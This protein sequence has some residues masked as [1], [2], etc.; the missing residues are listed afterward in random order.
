MKKTSYS[1]SRY[2]PEGTEYFYGYPA[3]ED[4][5]FYNGVP[6]EIEELVALRPLVCAGPGVK[7]FAFADA[8]KSD[9]FSIL[10]DDLDVIKVTNKQIIALP[11][12]INATKL[13]KERNKLLKQA[14]VDMATP[15]SLVMAQPYLD[16][17]LKQ[18]YRIPS[19]RIVWI[20]DKRNMNSYIPDQYLP[21]V[22]DEFLDGGCFYDAD[23]QL[24]L[25]CVVKVSS[26]SSGDGVRICRSQKDVDKAKEDFKHLEGIIFVTELIDF[27]RNFGVQFGIPHDPDQPIDIITWHEQLVDKKGAFVGGIIEQNQDESHLKTLNRVIVEK[28]L[29]EIRRKGWYGIGGFDILMT[30]DERFYIIDPNFRMTGMTVYDLLYK[31]K[32]I[33]SSMLSFMGTFEGS[34][35][36][37]QKKIVPLALP[38]SNQQMYITTLAQHGSTFRFNAA[39]LYET[40]KEIPK[41]ASKFLKSGVQSDVL[42]NLVD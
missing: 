8:L 41:I 32:D 17:R 13:G 14:L 22:Y 24:P 26:S 36:E 25:P 2:F 10:R 35:Q 38:G 21:E 33:E 37:F 42:T 16:S 31:N 1:L 28:I 20:N 34:L 27:E 19:H 23:E 15:G 18:Y 30:K 40:R 39:L 4:S 5:H 7:T 9:T 11:K 29:P 6:P 3:E 12:E